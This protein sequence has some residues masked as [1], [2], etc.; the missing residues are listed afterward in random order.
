MTDPRTCCQ[1]HW[2]QDVNKLREALDDL[3][4]FEPARRM[5]VCPVCGDKRCQRAKDCGLPCECETDAGWKPKCQSCGKTIHNHLGLEGTCQRLQES[6]AREANYREQIDS[7][8]KARNTA[9]AKVNAFANARDEAVKDGVFWK[10]RCDELEAALSEIERLAGEHADMEAD[11]LDPSPA[12]MN[13]WRFGVIV[14]LCEK[15]RAT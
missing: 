11:P 13:T 3:A 14:Q 4:W 2:K 8:M 7:L 5:I 6:L 1:R 10:E 15:A 9:Q 12:D